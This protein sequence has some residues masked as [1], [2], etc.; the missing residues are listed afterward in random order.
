MERKEKIIF[1][2]ILFIAFAL[3]LDF[4]IA[5]NFTLDS[6]EAIVG[7]MAKHINEGK[8]SPIF[9]YGQHYL[10]SLEAYAVAGLFKFFGFSA[11]ALKAV[12]LIFSLIFVVLVLVPLFFQI[13]ECL[14]S[15]YHSFSFKYNII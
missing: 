9:Y 4:L 8:T 7:L 3:R 14:I 6:D 10:G 11:I 12:P 1:I 2:L 5:N 15:F 13:I